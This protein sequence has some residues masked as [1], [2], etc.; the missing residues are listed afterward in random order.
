MYFYADAIAMVA[1]SGFLKRFINM[2][3]VINSSSGVKLLH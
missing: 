2:R 1:G 3:R